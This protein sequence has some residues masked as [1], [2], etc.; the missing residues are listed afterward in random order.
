MLRLRVPEDRAAGHKSC[1]LVLR[2]DLCLSAVKMWL[3]L[4]LLSVLL[5]LIVVRRAYLRLFAGRSPNPFSQDVKRPPAPL[6][7][8]KA[9]RKRVLKQGQQD[10][11]STPRSAAWGAGLAS[12]SP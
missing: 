3:S 11:G 4:L 1:A 8:D 9:A 2:P 10:Q 6:V 7:T 5:L 12:V